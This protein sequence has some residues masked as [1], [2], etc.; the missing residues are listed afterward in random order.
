M[1]E[2][3]QFPIL[4]VLPNRACLG[5][6]CRCLNTKHQCTK[7]QVPAHQSTLALEST[8][9]GPV[10]FTEIWLMLKYCER[11]TLTIELEHNLAKEFARFC[12]ASSFKRRQL[13][14]CYSFV[15]LDEFLCASRGDDTFFFKN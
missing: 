13:P 9:C 4:S 7:Q 11:K 6:H 3:Q 1:S 2:R 8:T 10:R 14:L 15:L 12:S 5:R